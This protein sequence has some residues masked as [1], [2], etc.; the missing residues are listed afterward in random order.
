MDQAGAEVAV[1]GV[2]VYGDALEETSVVLAQGNEALGM[3]VL[4][5][6]QDLGFGKWRHGKALAL[7]R[8]QEGIHDPA[9]SHR[10][11]PSRSRR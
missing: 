7:G 1:V 5:E 9:R 10:Q 2:G 3:V 4:G 11:R 8:G 6:L